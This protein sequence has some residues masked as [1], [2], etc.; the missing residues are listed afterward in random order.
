MVQ[1]PVEVRSPGDADATLIANGKAA[2]ERKRRETIEAYLWLTP[3]LAVVSFVFLYPIFEIFH[4]STLDMRVEPTFVGL[5][6]YQQLF[7]DPLFWQ[8][9]RDNLLLLLCIPVLVGFSLLVSSVL[10]DRVLGWQVY[11]TIVFLPYMMAIVVVGVA[12]G[13]ML[14]LE[15]ALN[16][17]LEAVGLGFLAQDWLGSTR[18]AL[19]SIGG[20]IVWRE[21]G[22]GT[23]LFLA[24]LMSVS[25]DLYDAAKVDGA[26]WWE[27][28]YYVTVPQLRNVIFLYVTLLLITLFSSLFNYIYVMTEAG[29]AFSTI[30]SEFYIYLHA[31][32]YRSMGTASAFSVILFAAALVIMVIQY[33]LRERAA[34]E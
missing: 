30:V 20:V 31:F 18:M 8:A 1:L 22:F 34:R 10:Y 12:F 32:K 23:M 15:G 13:Y 9:I 2:A 28:L 5:T 24:R 19:F 17:V 29:P 4:Y 27:R 26:S 14:Q 33:V 16:T 21:L 7:T 25:E 11:R 6:N 3:A